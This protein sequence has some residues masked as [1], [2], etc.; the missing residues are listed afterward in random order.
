MSTT[1]TAILAAPALAC[2]IAAGPVWAEWSVTGLEVKPWVDLRY[3]TGSGA[4]GGVH[5]MATEVNVRL[6]LNRDGEEFAALALG[7]NLVTD[8]TGDGRRMHLGNYY[9]IFNFGVDNPKLKVGRFVVPFGTLAEYDTHVLVL[10]TPYARTLG[11]RMDT[12][13]EVE[14]TRGGVN[15]RLS[16]T[17][18]DG[19]G[20]LRD[21]R[22]V[23]LRLARDFDSGDD[24]YR[25]GASALYGRNM[26]VLP[27]TA[28]PL[29]GHGD[30]HDGHAMRPA[31]ADKARL[32]LDL[33]WLRGIDN[34]RAEFVLGFDDDDFVHGQ[35]L[36]WNHPFSYETDLT[37]QADQWRGGNGRAYGLGVALHHRLDGFSG[38]RVAYEPRRAYPA[39]M[40]AES[41]GL[42]S[43][44]VYRTFDLGF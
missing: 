16:I 11:M 26:L 19:R 31:R 12:G 2:L 39:D 13:V 43:F 15:R 9:A 29:P 18:G 4:E 14:S 3:E 32:A 28:M 25:I 1:R 37:V 27:I 22:L 7:P 5:V 35:W 24:F 36:S 21:S 42:V 8:M 17:G 40:P 34:I 30:A 23:A 33:D 41:V 44:Q 20:R 10:Q 6:S 38:V